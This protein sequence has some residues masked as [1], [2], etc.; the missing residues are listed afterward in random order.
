MSTACVALR[1]SATAIRASSCV[2]LS[3]PFSASSIS[4]L[5]I[6]LFSYISKFRLDNDHIIVHGLLTRA[7]LLDLFCC[8]PN[9]RQDFS[10]D[11]KDYLR[12]F[13]GQWH[14][15]VHLETP[16]EHFYAPK[17]VQKSFMARPNVLR[18]LRAVYVRM[19]HPR[20]GGY[21]L[22]GGRRY[23]QRPL[24]RVRM[25]AKYMSVQISNKRM[26]LGIPGRLCQLSGRM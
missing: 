26:S 5:P 11:L 25:P 20:N 6:S 12:H 9:N 7:T 4:V 18:C 16:E 1:F 17:D 10:H 21:A 23:Q 15:C 14:P 22:K 13:C 24:S 8:N 2:N 3:S 19:T